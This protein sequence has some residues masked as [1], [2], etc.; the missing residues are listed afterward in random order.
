[1]SDPGILWGT[2]V[3]LP[4]TTFG[5]EYRLPHL[6]GIPTAVGLPST[7]L[8]TFKP[9]GEDSSSYV[10][11][12]YRGLKLVHFCLSE[13][14]SQIGI[15][16]RRSAPLC[17]WPNN[18]NSTLTVNTPQ[19]SVDKYVATVT[20]IS[21]V[22]GSYR[23]NNRGDSADRILEDSQDVQNDISKALLGLFVPWEQLT[24]L[25]AENASDITVFKEPRDA[26]AR[27]WGH[28]EPSLPPY[29]P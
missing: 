9:T 15:S 26:C 29:L 11:Y 3:L 6:L 4:G 12:I 1:M 2:V 14:L 5:T 21:V 7:T 16:T 20:V 17:R 22:Y 23:V 18:L 8:S 19:N 25:F 10:D 28:I 13:Y 27:I 24:P